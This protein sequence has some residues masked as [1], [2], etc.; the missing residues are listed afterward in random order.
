MATIPITT[1]CPEVT[2]MGVLDMQVCV[3]TDWTDEQI[4]KFAEERYPCGTTHGWR[5][6]K[7]GHRLIGDCPERVPCDGR[8]GFVHVMLDA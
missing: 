5:I 6:R 8:R 1:S 3:P 7:E 4:A 2:R